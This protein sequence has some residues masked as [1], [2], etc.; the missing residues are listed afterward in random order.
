MLDSNV[1]IFDFALCPTGTCLVNEEFFVVLGNALGQKDVTLDAS[2]MLP[3]KAV[4][5]AADVR[6]TSMLLVNGF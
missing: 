1:N 4:T 6:L 2:L 3:G 5:F